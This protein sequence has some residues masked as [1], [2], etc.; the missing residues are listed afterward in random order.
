MAAD[1]APGIDD[2]PPE[3]PPAAAV[4]HLRA[5]DTSYLETVEPEPD[6]LL[7]PWSG[8]LI[9]PENEQQCIAALRAVRE[10]EE[11]VTS[12]KRGLTEAI[13][14]RSQ[15]LGSKTIHTEDGRKAT[16]GP[17]SENV[18]D[19]EAIE[20][21]LREAGMPESRIRQI[22]REQVEYVVVAAEAK[23][24]A[25]ANPAYRAII[26]RHRSQRPKTVYV[27]LSS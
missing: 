27:S 19:A 15:V 10:M 3:G 23:K 5:D 25:A 14:A 20:R 26:E 7:V 2:A 24:A 9:D 22:V 11:Q 17:D 21:E 1:Q 18:Y 13:V 4:P 6:L 16:I 8:E 12:A